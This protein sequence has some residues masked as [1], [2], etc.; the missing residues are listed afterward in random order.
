MILTARKR[1][2]LSPG[3]QVLMDYLYVIVGSIFVGTAFSLFLLPNQIA[4]GGVSGISTILYGVFGLK[5]SLVQWV[6]NIPLFITGVVVLGKQYGLKTLV[7]TVFL[8]FVVFL[9]ENMEPATN[10][11]LLG[12]LFGGIGVGIGLGIL[13]RGRASTGGVDLIAQIVNK[14][15]GLSLGKCILLLDGSIVTISAI[16]FSIEQGLYALI[17]MFLTSKT[18]D[19]VQ[20]GL[21]Y[22]KMALII[23]SEEDKMRQGILKEID[24]GVTKISAFGGYTQQERPMLMC[25]VGQTEVTKLKR[26][27]K[28]IDPSAFVIVMNANEVFGEGFTNPSHT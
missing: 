22:S 21:G 19:I 20:M 10:D 24:R 25:V 16:V 5:P 13:F 11:P 4:S 28:T 3:M 14:Y 1:E 23:T 27:V 2:P 7:G 15:T 17:A 26:F 8:P 18:I 9:T 12:A 6:I